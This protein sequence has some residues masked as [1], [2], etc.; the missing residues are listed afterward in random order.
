MTR[1]RFCGAVG[2]SVTVRDGE[3]PEQ[4]VARAETTLL[5]L[6]DRNA[7]L[8]GNGDGHGPNIGLELEDV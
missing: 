6:L 1:V 7:K 4:A 8:L 3:T 5:L 2:G